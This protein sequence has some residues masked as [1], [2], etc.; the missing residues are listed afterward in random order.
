MAPE[1]FE[2]KADGRSDIYALG[3]TLYELLTLQPA[4]R[5]S[6][7][8]KL[9]HEVV[10]GDPLPPRTLN[11]HV[12]RDLETI[13]LKATSRA[14]AHRYQ[15][16]AELAEDLKRFLDDRPIRARP[17]S[18]LEKL[19]RL[20]RR[21]PA[22]AGLAAAF[23]LTLV[24]GAAG[25]TWKWLDAD[26]E[27]RKVILAESETAQQRD[28]AFS[29]RND[30]QRVL[31]GVMLDRGVALAGQGETGEGLF[32]ML[33]ALNVVPQEAGDLEHVIRTNLAAW[34]S[35]SHSLRGIIAQPKT[36]YLCAFSPDE[37]RFVTGS[38]DGVRTWDAA[39]VFRPA[40]GSDD[41]VG[42]IRWLETGKDP[43]GEEPLGLSPN[44]KML[45]TRWNPG[46]GQ[47][48][49][50]QRR[51]A[52]TGKAI[53]SP[54]PHPPPLFAVAF[55]PDG[56]HFATSCAKGIVQLW[57]SSTGNL[58]SDQFTHANEEI[59][60]LAISPDGKTLATGAS[61]VDRDAKPGVVYLWDL[62]GRRRLGRLVGHKGA[63]TKMVFSPQGK[64][65]LTCSWDSTAQLWDVATCSPIG[66]PLRHQQP[67]SAAQFTPD[68]RTIATGSV[69][70]KI[71]WWDA[72][73]GAHLGG[74]LSLGNL[75]VY[76]LVFNR[77]GNKLIAVGGYRD[78]I[79]MLHVFQLGR[80]L[81]RPVARH[82][83]VSLKA[84]WRL[85]DT[86]SWFTRSMVSYSPDGRH[87]LTGGNA[88]YAQ[89]CDTATGQPICADRAG[90]ASSD[91]KHSG[92][93]GGPFRHPLAAVHLTA[94][95]PDGRLLATS[96]RG[97]AAIGDACLWDA[98]SGRLIAALPHIN[99]VAAMAF[100]PDGKILATG[101][102]D[103]AVHL[104]DTAT[105][106]RLGEFLPQKDI[107]LSLAFS[108]NGKALAVGH[109]HDYSGAT[110]A[111]LW[112]VAG[113]KQIG[114]PKPGPG[115]LVRFSPDGKRLLTAGSRTIKLWDAAT[116]QHLGD[117]IT[118]GSEVN[119]VAFHPDGQVILL[120]G[121]DGTVRLRDVT[122]GK[123]IGAPMLHPV[124]AN[125]AAFS[126]DPE[127]KRILA[128]YGDGSAQ[129]WDRAT[130]KPLG[131]PVMQGRS[132]IGAAFGPDGRFFLTTSADGQTRRWPVPEATAD[133]PNRLA[134]RLEVLTGL[135]M[136]E[137]QT[138]GSLSA[139]E[140]NESCRRLAD[141]E[142]TENTLA[143]KTVTDREYHDARARDAEQD[144]DVYGALWHL[145]RLIQAQEKSA[146]ASPQ[147]DGW[148]AHARRARQFT[149]RGDWE[150]A[151][152]ED[153]RALDLGSAD[154]LLG[155]NKRQVLEMSAAEQWQ[156]ALWYI[157]RALAA[158]PA[159]WR[160]FADRSVIHGNLGKMRECED[161]L[162]QA[163]ARGADAAFLVR[164]ADDFARQ[165]QW[166]QA[167]AAFAK[168][169]ERG[170]LPLEVWHC[171]ALVCLKLAD[172]AGYRKI[173]AHLIQ[174]ADKKLSA[175]LANGVVWVSVLGPEAV[176]D[177]TILLAMAEV[178]EQNARLETK[179]NTLNSSGAV[180]YRAGRFKE[181][182]TR[183]QEGIQIHKAQGRPQVWLF[184]AMANQRV[185]QAVEARKCLARVP[186]DN[187]PALGH[188]ENLEIEMLRREARAMIDTK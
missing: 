20:C 143:E 130:Q 181:A 157:N 122:S 164:I 19:W 21:N 43:K 47:P 68:G 148:F 84:A 25:T 114:D 108:P 118:E 119:S 132:I 110:G 44:G 11:P 144:G 145:E 179:A 163:V 153:S 72:G 184:L 142:G 154:E 111:V 3:L 115:I 64:T 100:S 32:W 57:D 96:S 171:H 138:V 139:R 36:A 93:P 12:P 22:M 61:V 133:T 174:A 24:L 67:V 141:A 38:A 53:G 158:A 126:P 170:L 159:D 40:P 69:D 161:D 28:A 6:E 172:Q 104:W 63:I 17:A 66:S 151:E 82:Q 55:T 107:V 136:G 146:K 125:V 83:E 2:G 78:Q 37:S 52:A 176:G 173:C 4:F 76:D 86:E 33:E 140:W 149:L 5:A 127:G 18:G 58:V 168:A 30:S 34:M 103:C 166:Q 102:Y 109:S 152:A 98:G 45:L 65:V 39:A 185:G 135:G 87:A 188:W 51:E 71:S 1:R 8:H 182:I 187:I 123:P 46:N 10:R 35:Q 128:G 70:G 155:W 41:P 177:Y 75:G 81:S 92:G 183:I 80:A 131:P 62:A 99:Y 97:I 50:L 7:R 113:G 74:A 112:D 29:A 178:A 180:F 27:R 106:Q 77:D 54:L 175:H 117:P 56:K 48:A 16:A 169:H 89:V 88:G 101:G 31:A 120:A 121:T 95:S 156:P 91:P 15:S 160:L 49:Q 150:R 23:V 9:L 186:P 129:L 134:R 137:G 60:R 94:Y 13:V 167:E 14:P 59:T 79:G 26:A 73:A 165:A 90:A 162:S 105:G 124:R 116:S 42:P 85:A 147:P